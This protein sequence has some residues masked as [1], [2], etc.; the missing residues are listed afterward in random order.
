MKDWISP[1]YPYKVIQVPNAN[2]LLEYLCEAEPGVPT[3]ASTWRIRKFIY[4]ANNFNTQVLWADGDRK[5]DNLQTDY[6]AIS[7]S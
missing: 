3:S 7:Y 4:D 6:A 5:F 1:D 2:G